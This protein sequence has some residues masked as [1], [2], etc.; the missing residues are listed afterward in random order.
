VLRCRPRTFDAGDRKS[1]VKGS[2][3][4]LR[5]LDDSLFRG[6][7][8]GLQITDAANK[9]AGRGDTQVSLPIRSPTIAAMATARHGFFCMLE[10]TSDSS[11]V[12]LSCASE[13]D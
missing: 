4:V 6:A 8:A 12:N 10:P 3:E 13:V 5:P 9:L 1:T 2:R 7:S 11:D